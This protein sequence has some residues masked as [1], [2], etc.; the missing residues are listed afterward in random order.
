MQLLIDGNLS[1]IREK[2]HHL[3]L[4]H[5]QIFDTPSHQYNVLSAMEVNPSHFYV[6]MA[7]FGIIGS[8]ILDE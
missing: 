1:Y 4:N 8:F 3:L 6:Q 2:F 5:Y 7:R